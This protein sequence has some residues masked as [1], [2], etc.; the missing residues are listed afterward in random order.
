MR[1]E[2]DHA[3][4]A[5]AV[6]DPSE[7]VDLRVGAEHYLAGPLFRQQRLAGGGVG[8]GAFHEFLVVAAGPHLDARRRQVVGERLLV[9]LVDGPLLVG[10]RDG[11]ALDVVRR[12]VLAGQFLGR[13]RV[14]HRADEVRDDA[15]G[16]VGALER[17]RESES[18][19]R[20]EQ[21]CDVAV[22]L[23]PEVVDLV[24]HDQAE[25]V[26][27][28]G[29]A[30]V[31]GGVRRDRDRTD[32]LDA[33]AELADLD[34]EL[35]VQF[36]APL[37]QEVDGRDD[38]E[39]PDADPFDRRQREDG[40]A[41]ARRQF[42]DAPSAGG[43]PGLD[44]VGLVLAQPVRRRDR[45]VRRREDVVVDVDGRVRERLTQ[46]RVAPARCPAVAR[47]LV[48]PEVVEAGQGLREGA[49]RRHPDRS[50][51]EGQRDDHGSG[52]AA[53]SVKSV[54]VAG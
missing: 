54:V 41:A 13:Q 11:H 25:P 47:P 26:A 45:Q 36:R 39:R 9:A 38:D 44:G 2:H 19:R 48:D 24:E 42:H 12:E 28:L 5:V 22:P 29:R 37:P 52:V 17:R 49:V 3:V 1:G 50:V 14:H 16:A 53:Q 34:V 6:E 30:P 20:R 40:L 8:A 31:R 15:V 10:Q 21:P 7:G 33:A 23:A 35:P 27:D 43:G 32:L 4:L 46:G 18:V 51:R